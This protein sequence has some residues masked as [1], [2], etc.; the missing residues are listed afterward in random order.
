VTLGSVT[1]DRKRY[2]EFEALRHRDNAST[3]FRSESVLVSVYVAVE[4]HASDY[5]GRGVS[6][7]D[8]A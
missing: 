7:R 3:R 5:P 2:P 1:V 8:E 6:K 4:L